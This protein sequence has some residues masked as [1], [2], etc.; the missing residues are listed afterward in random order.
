MNGP[1]IVRRHLHAPLSW[2][3][4]PI[5]CG[6]PS[7]APTRFPRIRTHCLTWENN[8]SLESK[9]PANK[10]IKASSRPMSLHQMRVQR[11]WLRL[12]F[13]WGSR[14][15]FR[16]FRHPVYPPSVMCGLVSMT[17]PT[18]C[19]MAWQIQ[20]SEPSDKAKSQEILIIVGPDPGS[21]TALP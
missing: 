7:Q 5:P 17:R 13:C 9:T 20:T 11:W 2:W 16:I 10:T 6:L 21:G 14:S 8:A 15:L 3:I 18:M 1:T 19:S 4:L 12:R